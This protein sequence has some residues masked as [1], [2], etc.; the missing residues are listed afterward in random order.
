MKRSTRIWMTV[1][2]SLALLFTMGFTVPVMAETEGQP[3]VNENPEQGQEEEQFEIKSNVF[4]PEQEAAMISAYG[5]YHGRNATSIP[6]LTY[7][8][9][10]TNKQKKKNKAF[11]KSSLHISKS[12][13]TKQ[14]KY[15]KKKKYR[16]INCEEF[17]LWHEGKISLPPKTVM[18]TFDDG[19]DGVVRNAMPVLRKYKLK[20]TF[21]VIGSYVHSGRPGFTTDSA[22]QW[23]H[24]AYPKFELQSHTY[25]LHY[26]YPDDH[27]YEMVMRDAAKEDQLYGFQFHAYPYGRYTEKMVQAYKDSGIKMAFTYGTNRRATRSQDLYKIERVKVSAGVSFKRFKKL[28]KVK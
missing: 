22:M 14:M 8:N 1:I 15:L 7:H 16:T 9:V 11:K 4:T 5:Y 28:V 13:F 21:F 23:A 24:A 25:D 2:L 3:A 17:Y 12:K 27:A 6:V 19:Y 26:M 10:V 18:I 20:G